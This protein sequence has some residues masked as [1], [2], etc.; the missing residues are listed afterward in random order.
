MDFLLQ[1]FKDGG[2]FMI[3]IGI[4]MLMGL[5]III[6]RTYAIMF[7]YKANGAMLMQKIQRL[8][9][10]NNIDEAVKLCNSRKKAAVYQIF[11]AALVSSDR[12]IE[13]IQ[14]HLEVAN[15]SVIPKLQQRMPYLSTI[16]NVATLLGLLGT[17]VGLIT[18]FQAVGAVEGSQKQLLLSTGISTAM[19]TTAFGLIVAIPCSLAY[20]YLYNQINT[21]VDEIEHYSGRL[22]LLLRTGSQYFEFEKNETSHKAMPFDS[23]DDIAVEETTSES[24]KESND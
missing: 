18:T 2:T 24:E 14:D 20:G 8:I 5:L 15:M 19:N 17:I 13:E 1:A 16:A 21:I 7:V 11:K 9:L 4:L 23:E 12:P 3:P 10:D 6:E 22:L